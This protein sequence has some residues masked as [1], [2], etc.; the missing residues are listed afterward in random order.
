M[1]PVVGFLHDGSSEGCAHLA[2]AFRQG[3]SQAGLVDRHSVV[4]EDRAQ[5]A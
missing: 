5:I 1:M 4:I 3:L 2:A